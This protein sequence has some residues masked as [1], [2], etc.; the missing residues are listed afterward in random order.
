MPMGATVSATVSH[1][2]HELVI[3]VTVDRVAGRMP[4][5]AGAGSNSTSEAISSRPLRK[6]WCGCRAPGQPYHKTKPGGFVSS[7]QGHC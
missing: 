2:E 4:V 7:L 1:E 5:V 3:K 6:V